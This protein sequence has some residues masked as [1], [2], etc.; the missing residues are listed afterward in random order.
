[1]SL[2]D[3]VTLL[4]KDVVAS[5]AT[6]CEVIDLGLT[7]RNLSGNRHGAGYLNVHVNTDM[8]AT[9]TTVQLYHGDTS[10]AVSTAVGEAITLT[11][12]KAGDQ[13]SVR[14]P[15]SLK[16]FITAKFSAVNTGKVDVFIG[17]PLAD[18]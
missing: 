8:S 12:A 2:L 16:Q 10:S 17:V 14:L 11:S 13:F 1:M 18:H 4:G 15:K 9:A 6:N 5:S 3:D 7:G